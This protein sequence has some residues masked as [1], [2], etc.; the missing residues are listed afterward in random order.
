MAID[1][2]K[3]RELL[4][5]IDTLVDQVVGTVSRPLAD[6]LKNQVMGK[7]RQEIRDLIENSRS[8]VLYL[9]GRSGHGKSS[10]INALA[11]Q[12][13]AEVGHVKPTTP[14]SIPY[15]IPFEGLYASWKVIDSRGIF[16]TTRPDGAPAKDAV[17]VVRQDLLTHKPDV[18][19]HLIAAPEVR[20]LSN[21]LKVL[22]DMLATLKRNLGTTPPVLVVL[23]KTDTLGNPRQWPPEDHPGK[24]GL[25]RELLDYMARDVL[26]L[27]DFEA[28]FRKAPDGTP[29]SPVC[30]GFRLT[31]D[32]QVRFIIPVALPSGEDPWNIETLSE[33][34][35]AVLPQDARLEFFQAQRRKE[36]LRQ[37]SSTLISRFALIASTVGASPIPVSDFL[38]LTPLQMLMISI[39]GGLSCRPMNVGTAFEFLGACGLAV[40]AGTALRTTAQQLVKLIPG[41]GSVVSATIAGSGTYGIGKSAESYFFYGTKASPESFRGE[42]QPPVAAG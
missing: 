31:D 40:G 27:K 34:I 25:I 4:E 16:E 19:L 35:G 20:N 32:S 11:N 6:W 28:L 12:P 9:L 7:A 33:T 13:V 10:L 41:F 38:I 36:L 22:Q 23:T 18:L 37:M 24:A 17:E 21:D 42:W 39:V 15:T 1:K 8:P 30:R 2:N 26:R 3:A 5:R 29:A 14:E